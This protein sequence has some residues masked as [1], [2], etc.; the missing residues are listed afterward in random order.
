M[1]T[2]NAHV[3][4]IVTFK[5]SP[6]IA[7]ETYL[8][9]TQKSGDWAKAHPGFVSRLISRGDDGT[10]SDVTVWDSPENAKA[11][12]S[13][14]MEQEFAGEMIGMIEKDSFSMHQRPILWQQS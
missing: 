8:A 3:V 2:A 13:S 9:V 7:P 6:E 1:T 5:L 14:F 11:S 10:W 12:Q 4:E